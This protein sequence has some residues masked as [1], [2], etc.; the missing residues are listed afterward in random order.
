VSVTGILSRAAPR[1]WK[2]VVASVVGPRTSLVLQSLLPDPNRCLGTSPHQQGR[3]TKMARRSF[4][5]I[6]VAKH[7]L[8]IEICRLWVNRVGLTVNRRL[9]LYPHQRTSSDRPGRSGSVES[10]MGAVARGPWPT[11]RFPSPLIEPDVP[12][13]GIRLSDW[14]HREAHG[15]QTNRTRLRCGE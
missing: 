9:P 8:K 12:I 1:G 15:E 2:P 13:S 10:R 4:C 14:F 7:R 6:D 3:D 5:G 11:L